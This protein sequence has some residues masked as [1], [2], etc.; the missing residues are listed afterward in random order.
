MATFTDEQIDHYQ[1][2]LDK[3]Q[4]SQATADQAFDQAQQRQ[5]NSYFRVALDHY[6]QAV[7][8]YQAT[9]ESLPTVLALAQPIGMAMVRKQYNQ[10]VEIQNHAQN[11][12]NQI[13]REQ[14][15]CQRHVAEAISVFDQA[16]NHVKNNDFDSARR[17]ARQVKDIDHSFDSEIEQFL[18]E[19][20]PDPQPPPWRFWAIA[21][22]VLIG[23][24][25]FVGVP[26]GKEI[27]ASLNPTVVP[28][29]STATPAP[30]TDTP[31]SGVVQPTPL[32]VQ[33]SA[34][35]A[36]NV[37]EE[38]NP[39]GRLAFALAAG[40]QVIITHFM[41][42]PNA[43]TWL[44][45]DAKGKRGWVQAQSIKFTPPLPAVLEQK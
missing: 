20:P 25:V 22:A 4:V 8:A 36:V 1:S 28:D 35:S 7:P 32:P 9:I 21:A 31:L 43:P 12:L 5:Q 19:I 44:E 40:D 38:A 45:V 16:R 39:Q 3:A 34:T 23:L 29:V 41:G 15:T 30:P 33:A 10:A 14:Q 24:I 27:L 6:G 18:N 26:K 13:E 17:D 42:S 2:L 11:R 37:L